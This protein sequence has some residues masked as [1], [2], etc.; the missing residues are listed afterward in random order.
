MAVG[1]G[2]MLA[3]FVARRENDRSRFLSPEA[4]ESVI[5]GTVIWGFLGAR[6][7]YVW[8]QR[9]EFIDRCFTPVGVTSDCLAS[10]KI[11]EGGL[12]FYGGPIASI[13]FLM[14]FFALRKDA[15]GL[16]SPERWTRFYRFVDVCVPPLALAHAFGR[17]GCL[18]AGCCFGRV[19]ESIFAMHYP[20][21]NLNFDGMTGRYP[22]QLVEAVFETVIFVWLVTMRPK[23]RFHGQITLAYFMVYPIGRTISEVYRGD[24]VRG[25]VTEIA[26]PGFNA[27]M[28]LPAETVSLLTTSQFISLLVGRRGFT[29]VR[30][31]E[32]AQSPQRVE[33]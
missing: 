12:V 10:F 28:G 29:L 13:M 2:L 18:F 8:T 3:I 9:H 32:K 6:I 21:G 5:F 1:L 22:V 11:W 19:S 24:S 14:W 26:S 7:L 33:A 23:K 4:C 31:S 30:G 27:L 17:I 25:F 15:P 20:H 16:S